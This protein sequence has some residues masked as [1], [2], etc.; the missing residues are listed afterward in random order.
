VVTV[1]AWSS[2]SGGIV[3]APRVFRRCGRPVD[4]S[5]HLRDP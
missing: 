4:D 3:E 5:S 2:A 1:T